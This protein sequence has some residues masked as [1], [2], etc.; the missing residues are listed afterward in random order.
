MRSAICLTTVL[1]TIGCG[2][3]DYDL[4]P[5]RGTVTLDGKPIAGARVIFEPRRSGKEALSAGPGSDGITDE[6]GQYSLLTT[7]DGARGAVVG[8]H[9]VTISTFQAEVDRSRDSSRVIRKEEIPARYFQPGALSYEVPLAG[10]D[11]A[12]FTLQTP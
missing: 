6:D 4:V 5:V 7:V 1:W 8:Q 2:S 11:S 3:S 10:T 12:N 9:T